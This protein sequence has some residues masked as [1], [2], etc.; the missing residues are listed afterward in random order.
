[1]RE[2]L[3]KKVKCFTHFMHTPNLLHFDLPIHIFMGNV[4]VQL[5]LVVLYLSK[6]D[7]FGHSAA[8]LPR[9]FG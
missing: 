6:T 7:K 1:M 3:L 5:I 4:I 2:Y 9:F 8:W